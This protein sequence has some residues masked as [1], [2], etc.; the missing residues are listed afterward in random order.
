MLMA[1]SGGNPVSSYPPYE[2]TSDS[3]GAGK[4]LHAPE[5]AAAP[6]PGL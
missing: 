6:L 1:R 3:K 5:F 4:Q 2:G